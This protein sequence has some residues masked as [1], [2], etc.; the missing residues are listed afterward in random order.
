MTAPASALTHITTKHE[1]CCGD[2]MP[3]IAANLSFKFAKFNF[4]GPEFCVLNHINLHFHP[5]QIL[6]YFFSKGL[7]NV[8]VNDCPFNSC[9]LDSSNSNA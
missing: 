1:H 3:S 2:M 5:R 4:I 8:R 7:N 9:G 6:R